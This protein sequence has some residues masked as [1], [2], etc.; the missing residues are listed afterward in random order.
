MPQN[1]APV[2]PTQLSERVV[3]ETPDG[4]RLVEFT[5]TAANG[6]S[7]RW[8]NHGA[9]LT[10]IT[11]PDGTEVVAGFEDPEDYLGNHPYVGCTIGPVANRIA[12]GRFAVDEQDYAVAP[13]EGANLLHSGPHGYHTQLWD[14]HIVDGNRLRL[15]LFSRDQDRGWPSD[16]WAFLDVSLSEATLDIA[17]RAHVSRP[18]PVNMTLH[19]YFNPAGTFGAPVDDFTLWSPATA[20]TPVNAERI[21]TESSTPAGRTAFDLSDYEPIGAREIDHNFLVPG[22][23]QRLLAT[24]TDGERFIYVESDAPGLQVFTGHTVTDSEVMAARG[25]VAL[26]PQSPPDLVNFDPEAA[27]SDVDQ[28]FMRR[29]TYRFAGPGLPELSA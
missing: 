1:R 24:V 5:F 8:L 2:Q 20:Y 13:N 12:G 25:A 19:T 14:H 18:S 10:G 4:R 29:I 27:L 22:S 6:L 21:P 16:S 3:G 15:S 9:T 26:E 23:G 28:P 17:M 7:A 11:L